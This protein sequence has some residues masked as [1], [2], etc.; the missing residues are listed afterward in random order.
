[1]TIYRGLISIIVCLSGC[2]SITA[3]TFTLTGRV[4]DENG[5]GLEMATITIMPEMAVTFANIKG[6]Y[7]ITA[8][9]SDSVVVRFSTV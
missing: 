5:D 1:M 6:D 7:K 8:H 3:Q 9:T 4:L 2:L